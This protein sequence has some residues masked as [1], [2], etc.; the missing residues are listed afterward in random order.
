MRRLTAPLDLNISSRPRIVSWESLRRL[1][2]NAL[3]L[4]RSDMTI[5]GD[6]LDTKEAIDPERF[7]RITET[8]ELNLPSQ[9]W[10]NLRSRE[11]RLGW[12]LEEKG[13][14]KR[15][16]RFE[17]ENKPSLKLEVTPE[18]SPVTRLSLLERSP[19]LFLLIP[20]RVF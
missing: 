10:L 4:T 11:L 17:L 20:E 5:D 8:A 1:H 13:E 2:S 15:G 12:N 3:K 16:F 19:P 18:S 14:R 9:E 7:W 6:T